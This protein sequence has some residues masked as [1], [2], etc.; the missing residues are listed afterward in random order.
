[1][2]KFWLL[3]SHQWER[4]KWRVCNGKTHCFSSSGSLIL[5]LTKPKHESPPILSKCI[6]STYLFSSSFSFLVGTSK[7]SSTVGSP[8]S[9]HI[10][11]GQ[12]ECSFDS[13]QWWVVG[14][15]P[16]IQLGR[17]QLVAYVT[18]GWVMLCSH[19]MML[20][21]SSSSSSSSSY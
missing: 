6:F 19:H 21:S 4:H 15:A 11:G 10:N 12:W 3:K 7:L 8:C 13:H 9:I 14:G 20:S 1:M 16:L 17:T 2:G 18:E 5:L